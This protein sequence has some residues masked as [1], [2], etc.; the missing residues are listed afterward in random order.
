MTDRTRAEQARSKTA[1]WFSTVYSVQGAYLLRPDVG[2]ITA[3][4][5][6]GPWKLSVKLTPSKPGHITHAVDTKLFCEALAVRDVRTEFAQ[7]LQSIQQRLLPIDET[8]REKLP[9]T[10]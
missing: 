6:E 4:I 9:F 1:M 2:P 7:M 10:S 8:N 5:P 3:T